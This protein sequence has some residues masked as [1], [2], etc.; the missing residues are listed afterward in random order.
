MSC[1]EERNNILGAVYKIIVFDKNFPVQVYRDKFKASKVRG[2][3]NFIKHTE[4][5]DF[6][7]AFKH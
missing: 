6:F 7:I 1:S 5:P 4:I 2:I 3:G